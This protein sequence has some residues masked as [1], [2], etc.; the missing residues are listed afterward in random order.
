MNKAK[1]VQEIRKKQ[2][3]LC[4][5]LDTDI[6]RI[7][8]YLLDNFDDP[9]FEFNKQIIENTQDTCVAYKFNIAFYEALGKD[10]WDIL[11]RSLHLVPDHIFTIADAKRG[12]IGNTSKLYAKTFFETMSFDAITVSPYMGIDS[13]EPFYSYQDKWVIIL[14]L[15]SNRGSSQVQL[16]KTQAGRFVYEH[17]IE[18]MSQIGDSGNTMFVFGATKPDFIASI[19]ELIPDHFL[20]VPGIGS[21]GGNL[22]RTVNDGLNRDFGLLINSSRGIIY[23]GDSENF[24]ESARIASLDLQKQMKELIQF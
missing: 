3:L 7:P 1:L 8:R 15:T 10:G 19:R 16:L 23:A 9:I 24:A 6:A 17:V 2:S 4:V 11:E 5:G 21:Q 22:E 18:S 12:D 20:L 14:G 13:I